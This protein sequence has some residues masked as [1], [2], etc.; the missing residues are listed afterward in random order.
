MQAVLDGEVLGEGSGNSKQ[1]AG[2]EAARIALERL[3]AK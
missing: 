1:S 3:E 2:Q